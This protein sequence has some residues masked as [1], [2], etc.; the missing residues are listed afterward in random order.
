VTHPMVFVAQLQ[1]LGWGPSLMLYIW[2]NSLRDN[3]YEIGWRYF[4]IQRG[5]AD[6]T[7][8]WL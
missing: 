8:Q 5:R 4:R 7:V 3:L 6:I 2:D 1:L